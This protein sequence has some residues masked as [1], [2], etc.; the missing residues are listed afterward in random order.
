MLLY[1]IAMMPLCEG[2]REHV[3]ESLQTWFADKPGAAGTATAEL[4]AKVMVYMA[5]H[6]PSRGYHSQCNKSCYVCK[7]EDKAV[8]GQ[9]FEVKGLEIQFT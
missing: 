5:K 2:T 9:V 3:K 6:G 1:G 7:G 8:A 4:N